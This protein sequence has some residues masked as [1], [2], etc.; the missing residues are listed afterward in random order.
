M[1]MAYQEAAPDLADRLDAYVDQI[2]GRIESL[3]RSATNVMKLVGAEEPD[4]LE[5]D[6]A[7]FVRQEAQALK[8]DLPGDVRLQL[9]LE[10]E[11][12]PALIDREQMSSVLENLVRNAVEALPEEEAI[13]VQTRLARSLQLSSDPAPRNH[14]VLEVMDTGEGMDAAVRARAFEPGFTR[15]GEGTGLGLAIGERVASDHGGHVE[16]ESEPG[17]GTTVCV[18]L[19]VAEE[20]AG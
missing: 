3:R 15:S 12:P 19:P 18:Y 6:L 17:V 4:P 2:E 1:Q 9:E 16:I 14:L 5:T 8:A 11:L 10:E 20:A 7:V 13:T